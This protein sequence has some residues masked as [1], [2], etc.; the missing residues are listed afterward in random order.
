MVAIERH[1]RAVAA[2][3]AIGVNVVVGFG[4]AALAQH[5]ERQ[6]LHAASSNAPLLAADALRCRPEP[7]RAG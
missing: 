6:A 5:Y 3:A 1:A 4:L 2:I 7:A